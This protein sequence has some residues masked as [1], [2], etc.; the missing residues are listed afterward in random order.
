MKSE[1]RVL[2]FRIVYAILTLNFII[3][4]ISYVVDPT[5][6]IS[7]LDK[8]NRALGGGPYPFA[9]ARGLWHML[10]A[11]DVMTL[12]VMCALLFVDLRRFFPVLPALAFCKGFSAVYAAFIFARYG[13]PAFAAIAVLD[14]VTTL[15]MIFFAVR[16]RRA[17]DDRSDPPKSEPS[18]KLARMLLPGSA[19]IA[20]SLE[21]IRSAGIVDHVPTMAGIL[22]GVRR[23]LHRLVFRSETIGTCKEHPVRATWRAKLLSWR[24]VRLPFLVAERAVAPFD[25]SGLASPPDRVIRHLLAAHHD[26]MQ[27]V[28]DLELLALWPGRLEELERR[29]AAVVDGTDPRADWLRD[30]VVFDGYHENLLATTRAFRAGEPLLDHAQANDPDISLRA[31]LVWCSHAAATAQ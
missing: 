17:L 13:V 6:A 11:G 4:A 30:L 12:G 15:A 20:R 16:A 24:I 5:M 28:Y 22:R 23:M 7:T 18:E 10:G 26:G 29:A 9:D 2:Q 14:S 19:N 25:L 3:P 21:R 31:F 27:L 8:V 1:R